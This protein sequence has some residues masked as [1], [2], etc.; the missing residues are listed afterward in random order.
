MDRA[1]LSR[2]RVDPEVKEDSGT[3]SKYIMNADIKIGLV[4]SAIHL[5]QASAVEVELSLGKH[6]NRP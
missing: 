2:R 6:R 1:Y 3:A 4:S 5:F